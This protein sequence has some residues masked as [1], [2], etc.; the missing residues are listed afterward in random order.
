LLTFFPVLVNSLTG[1]R[2]ADLA[3]HAVMQ[4]WN[5]SRWEVFVHLRWKAQY[6]FLLAALKTVAPLS[7]VGAVVAEW[8]G[9]SSGLGQ[10]MW[11]AYNNL[12]LPL[13]FAAAFELALLGTLL[14]Q[15]VV[16]MEKRLY[17]WNL[18]D[19]AL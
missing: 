8:L 16:F 18:G 5:A 6:P 13:L 14:Y 11:L 9:A 1:M 19:A 15:V 17:Y 4:S 2:A 10:L 12:N 3:V 7:L